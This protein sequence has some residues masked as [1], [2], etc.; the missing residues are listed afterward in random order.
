[1]QGRGQQACPE[2]E[3][4]RKDIRK[5]R[6]KEREKEKGKWEEGGSGDNITKLFLSF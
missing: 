5:K 2:A 4:P 1:M 3:N 6:R